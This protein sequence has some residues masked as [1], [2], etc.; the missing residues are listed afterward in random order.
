MVTPL[1][2]AVGFL[3]DLTEGEV[4]AAQYGE[5][6]LQQF[7]GE[8][9]QTGSPSRGIKRDY[10]GNVVTPSPNKNRKR[11]S[12]MPNRANTKRIRHHDREARI[13][14]HSVFEKKV[15]RVSRC[16]YLYHERIRLPP[17]QLSTD[18]DTEQGRSYRENDIYLKGIKILREWHGKDSTNSINL[19]P[20][21]NGY[22]GPQLINWCLIQFDCTK[23]IN[24]EDADSNIHAALVSQWWSSKSGTDNRS[25]P[26]TELDPVE[27]D[28]TTAI[29]KWQTYWTTGAI[30]PHHQ[31]QFKILA[32]EQRICNQ[33]FRGGDSG[34]A[35]QKNVARIHK[36]FKIPTPIYLHNGD[37]EAWGSP[38]YEVWW[39]SPINSNYLKNYTT[40]QIANPTEPQQF[41]EVGHTQVYF[42][43]LQT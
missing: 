35:S 5:T 9:F 15:N 38:I 23:S 6:Q 29:G 30:N 26:F 2:A 4:V 42:K 27:P 22:V 12:N 14:S 17:K 18:M 34:D 36:Y 33:V 19:N 10:A 43:D 1:T 11:K 40:A 25:T 31:A 39:I 41:N 7:L 28:S 32:R 16:G 8:E 37:E 3:T 21:N 13:N 20:S 24:A